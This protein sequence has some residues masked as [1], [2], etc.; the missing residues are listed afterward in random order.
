VGHVKA[1]KLYLSKLED[2][3]TSMVLL[4]SEVDSKAH[5]LFVPHKGKV[6][7]SCDVVFVEK[8]SWE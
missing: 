6:V 1:T 4:G 5:H 8:V 3:C 7:V 2:W